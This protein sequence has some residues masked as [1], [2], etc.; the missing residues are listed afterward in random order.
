MRP[1]LQTCLYCDHEWERSSRTPPVRCPNC[2][3]KFSADDMAKYHESIGELV[4]EKAEKEKGQ[5]EA[6]GCGC[7]F[8]LIIGLL[9][10]IFK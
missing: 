4:E 9:W 2:G 8:L 1:F 5:N 7:V 10:W 3:V 6:L